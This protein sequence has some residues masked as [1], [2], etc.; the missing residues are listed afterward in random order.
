MGQTVFELR[1]DK[2]LL[3]ITSDAATIT[4]K[5]PGG[6]WECTDPISF[7]YGQAVILN[8][9]RCGKV[10]M[11]KVGEEIRFSISQ[12]QWLARFPGHYYRKPEAGPDMTFRFRIRL[13]DAEVIF[14]TEVPEGLDDESVELQFPVDPIRFDTTKHG[15]AAASVGTLGTMY[16][17]PT[18]DQYDWKYAGNLPLAGWFD[19]NG[20]LGIRTAEMVDHLL[21]AQVNCGGPTGIL[22]I[23]HEF[24][25]GKSEYERS[26]GLR[27]FPKGSS[28]VDLAK[29][30]RACVI[31]ENRFKSLKEKIAE[32]PEV[33][34][35]A[36]SVIWKHNTYPKEVPPHIQKDYSLYVWTKE[37]AEA[38]GRP[39]N[40]SAKEV[41]DTAHAAG[42]DRVCIFNTGWNNKGYDSGYPTRFPPNPERGTEADF[43]AAAAYGKSL[44]DGYIFS[45][46]DNYRDVYPNSEEFSFD[47]IL[48]KADGSMLKG[49]IWRG[50]RCYIIC[51]KETL[52]YAR[53]D[54]K[55]IGEMCGRGAIYLD[56]QGCERLNHCYHP[57]HPASKLDDAA[58]RIETFRE[59]RKHI[60]AVATEG[61][62]HE[63]AVKEADVGAY[64]T[65]RG[66]RKPSMKPIPLFQLVYHD[67]IMNFCGPGTSGFSGAAYINRVALYCTLPWDF[68]PDSLRISKELRSCYTAEMLTHEFLSDNVE[69]TV[70]SDGTEVFANFGK[71][72][73]LG[74]PAESYKIKKP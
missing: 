48:R 74:I 65:F 37:D 3:T 13:E 35:L 44:S 14:T 43:T 9:V 46:H 60:G 8:L 4:V 18:I 52:K 68:S 56:V 25:K 30:H 53:R 27:F 42:F 12:I 34:L 45:V 21:N 39:A 7:L 26:V 41:F 64:A 69:H 36:G 70:F 73:E 57:D 63:F 31:R 38:E 62:P 15:Y 71:T 24:D 22:S 11:E 33:E 19:E 32:T 58:C 23:I 16:T 28:Y 10:D 50:G 47:E 61:A 5:H 17:F 66:P 51:G 72:E 29:W 1:N 59:A 20:G 6:T 2:L 55:R 49:G 54:L 40:W 67:S